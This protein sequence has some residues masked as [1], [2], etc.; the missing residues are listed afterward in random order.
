MTK[1]MIGY[2]S[3]SSWGWTISFYISGGAGLVWC[4]C[5]VFLSSDRPGNHPY[6]R[7][8]ERKYIELALDQEKDHMVRVKT[9]LNCTDEKCR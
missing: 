3:A 2:L 4:V 8:E 6:I 5:W 7:L 1:V 9:L